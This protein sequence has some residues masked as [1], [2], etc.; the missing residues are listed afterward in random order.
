MS[1]PIIVWFRHDLRLRDNRALLRAVADGAPVIPLYILDDDTPGPW[2]AGGA[3][4]WW[5]HHS[6]TALAADLEAVGSRLVLR[7]GKPLEVVP[8]LADE[9]KAR[10]VHVSRAYQPWAGELESELKERLGHEDVTF[11]RFSGTLL[12]EPEAVTT[13]DGGP[14]K[15]YSP[16]WRAASAHA[17]IAKP[18]PAP[19]KIAAPARWPKSDTL[20]AWHLLPAKPDWAGGLGETWAPGEAGAAQRLK[21]FLKSALASYG[22]DRNRPDLMGTSRLSPHLAHGEI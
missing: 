19:K 12:F 21:L 14:F 9:S 11:R 4:R 15:V 13:K 2:R 17:D 20:A 3:S 8:A 7:R 1:Q 10:A 6:L 16:F 18:E 5:L 22:A